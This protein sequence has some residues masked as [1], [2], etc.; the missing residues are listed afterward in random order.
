[1]VM[2]EAISSMSVFQTIIV[3][4]GAGGFCTA[5]GVIYSFGK[6]S[7]RITDI[8]KELKEGKSQFTKINDTLIEH[9]KVLAV[10]N[11]RTKKIAGER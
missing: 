6:K 9:G 3:L 1:M 8:E 2:Q 4:F 10:I 11:D 5:G 7:Q